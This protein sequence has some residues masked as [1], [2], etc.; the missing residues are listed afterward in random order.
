MVASVTRRG[1]LHRAAA[2]GVAATSLGSLADAPQAAESSRPDGAGTVQTVLGPINA[3][4]LGFTLPHEHIAN[5]PGVLERWPKA[6]G[7]RPGLVA[8]AVELLKATKAAGVGAIV[9]LTTY[10]V[11]RDIRFLEEVARRSGIHM[12]AATGQR[13]FPPKFPGVSMPSTGIAGLAEFFVKEIDRGVDGTG[14]KAGVIK[15]GIVGNPPTALEEK[16]LRAGV[17]ASKATGVPMRIHADA[18]Q[19]A[20]ER[21]AAILEHEG[22]NP[23]RVSFDHSDDSGD[24]DYF[25]RLVRRGYFLGMDHVHRGLAA[26][27]TPSFERR[28]ECIK[29]LVDAGFASKLF[30][31]TDSEF[32][33]ALL[34]EKARDWRED[35][36]AREG[37]LFGI[38]KLMPRLVELGVSARQILVM[39]RDN[40][41]VFFSRTATA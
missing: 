17:R 13:F 5:A 6:W 41:A 29:R 19:R 27:V 4:D 38:R 33:G 18:A 7:G 34:P 1:F 28:A 25:L 26:K 31:S 16:G 37:M 8:R 24:M 35:L 3:A 40:P 30:L 32:G 21:I 20:A 12:I 23:A 11:G 2:A 15:I 39:T 9:D 36:D 14:V 22:A 10:D